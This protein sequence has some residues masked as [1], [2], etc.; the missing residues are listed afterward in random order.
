M[1]SSI[2]KSRSEI[3]RGYLTKAAEESAA[4]VAK[5][6]VQPGTKLAESLHRLVKA[7]IEQLYNY[8]D[9]LE[10]AEI[11]KQTGIA[12]GDILSSRYAQPSSDEYARWP[13]E[14]RRVIPVNRT[15]HKYF[16]SHY[17]RNRIVLRDQP[18]EVIL[19]CPVNL[20]PF[21]DLSWRK[22]LNSTLRLDADY[23]R[24]HAAGPRY[25]KLFGLTLPPRVEEAEDG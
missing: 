17:L 5:L 9:L 10:L 23:G 2:L 24:L 1:S 19:S 8:F 11:S 18:W 25:A 3:Q 6:D 13:A 14:L 22:H 7:S 15:D 16:L 12:T 21:D 4:R 20:L